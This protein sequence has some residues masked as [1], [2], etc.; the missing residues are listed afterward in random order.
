M[1]INTYKNANDCDKLIFPLTEQTS[2]RIQL[3]MKDLDIVAVSLWPTPHGKV[4]WLA[5]TY[6]NIQRIKNTDPTISF[7]DTESR[8]VL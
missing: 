7:H 8:I 1:I 2:S 4:Y 6:G 3:N 5:H